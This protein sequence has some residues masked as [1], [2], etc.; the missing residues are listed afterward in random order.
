MID[1]LRIEL[2]DDDPSVFGPVTAPPPPVP[3]PRWVVP[4]AVAACLAVAAATLL[5]WQP[6]QDEPE[7]PLSNRL[8]LRNQPFN[9]VLSVMID[10]AWVGQSAGEVGLVYA[11]SDAVF[12]RFTAGKGRSAWWMA[13]AADSRAPSFAGVLSSRLVQ[14][15][16]AAVTTDLSGATQLDFGPIDGR[17]FTVITHGLS[18]DETAAIGEQIGVVDGEPV[19]RDTSVLLGMEPIGT[20]AEF[21]TAVALAGGDW[22]VAQLPHT[23][24]VYIEGD[25]RA[26]I[27]SVADSDGSIERLLTMLLDADQQ[28]TVDRRD[29]WTADVSEIG[30]GRIRSLVAWRERERLIVVRGSYDVADT[31]ATADT[32][33]ELNEAEWQR[34]AAQ[35]TPPGAGGFD[36]PRGTVG[37]FPATIGRIAVGFDSV[38][39]IIATPTVFDG[40][41]GSSLCLS[42]DVGIDCEPEQITQQ[43][44]S[45][46]VHAVHGRDLI[47]A[48]APPGSH[49]PMLRITR[50]GV[51]EL[52]LLFRPGGERTLP[53]PAVAVERTDD[54]DLVEL[55]VDGS[56]VATL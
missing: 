45:L 53:G 31:L 24:V 35:A 19:V 56:V 21:D 36:S 40:T 54:M 16:S 33:V 49:E 44:P 26:E 32:A 4:A 23:E 15:R 46:T 5:V 22:A 28:P 1:D 30:D 6:W 43:P 3:R 2:I 37:A 10:A 55:L 20:L 41:A 13:Y 29:V 47:L 39:E 27:D 12:P 8:A 52:H 14:G 9:E 7:P 42:T 11:D 18:A 17:R 25:G 38:G 51:T 50:G 34:I 48:L